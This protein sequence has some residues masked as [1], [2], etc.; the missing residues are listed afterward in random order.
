MD[1]RKIISF[2]KTSFVMSIPKSWVIKN[3]LK[4]GDLVSLEENEGNLIMSP[5]K[6]KIKEVLK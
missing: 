5:K 4:K 3:G 6:D 1:Y 2:G